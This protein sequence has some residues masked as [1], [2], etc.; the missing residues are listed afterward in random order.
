MLIPLND[1]VRKYNMHPKGVLHIGANEGQE[2]ADYFKAGVQHTFWVEPIDEIFEKLDKHV[3]KFPFK[4]CRLC[5]MLLT[6]EEGQEV[7]FHIA[8]N[9]G[10]SSSILNFGTHTKEH[11]TVKFVKTIKL[12]T[13]TLEKVFDD[14]VEQATKNTIDGEGDPNPFSPS[15]YDFLNIDVQGAE[16]KVLRGMGEYLDGFKWLYLEINQKPLYIGCPMVHEIDDYVA[17]FGF[18]RVETK[19]TGAGW[20]DCFMIKK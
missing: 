18:K 11:P 19:W 13:T 1:L 8:N 17:D 10:Q 16:L 12:K 14:L 7:D 9:D 2:A 4:T 15:N 6:D 5:N 20:G 3:S